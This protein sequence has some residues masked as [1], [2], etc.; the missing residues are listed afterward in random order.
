MSWNIWHGGREDGEELGPQRVVEI[1]KAHDIDVVA[2]QETYGS[3]ERISKALGFHF[4]PRGTNVSILSRY[5]ILE[6]LSVLQEFQCVGALLELPNGGRIAVY[7]LWLPYKNDIWLKGARN[8]DAPGDMM[9]AC[10]PSASSLT[11]IRDAIHVRLAEKKY[12]DVPVILAGDFNSM[13]HLDYGLVALSQFQAVV[14]WPTSHVLL[15]CGF[16]DSYRE[17]HPVID[18]L[19]DRTWSPRFADQEQDRIDFIYYKGRGLRATAS[20]VV[21]EHASGFPSDHA[22]VVTTFTLNP[23]SAPNQ[24]IPLRVATYNIRHGRGMD[25]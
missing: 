2:M 15:D 20:K 18:R 7:S 25:E 6:D 16:V 24:V 10:A 9:Q 23:M 19:K 8:C 14:D 13:S 3:G 22:A 5:P 12:A 11:L 17:H 21:N 1:I 4:H